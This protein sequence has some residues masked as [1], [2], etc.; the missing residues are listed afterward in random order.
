MLEETTNPSI[1]SPTPILNLWF[2]SV[3][4]PDRFQHSKLLQFLERTYHVHPIVHECRISPIIQRVYSAMYH[5]TSKAMVHK[6]L[7][8]VTRWLLLLS[9][10]VANFKYVLTFQ[11]LGNSELH[12]R[13]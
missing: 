1:G 3:L 4:G 6:G 13:D 10:F 5:Y 8:V 7:Q 2:Q 12:L 9:E 11:A